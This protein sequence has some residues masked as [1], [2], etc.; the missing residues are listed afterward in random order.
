MSTRTSTHPAGRRVAGRVVEQVVDRTREPLARALDHDGLQL[1]LE[2][3]ARRVAPRPRDGLGD[4]IVEAH[5]LALA[6]RLVAARELDQVGDEH[7]EL[8]RL[9]LDVLQQPRALVGRQRL[10]LGQHLDVRAQ[11]GDRRAQ[12]VRGVGDELALGGDRAL[13]RVEHRVEVLG[14]LADL[15]VA[16]RPRSGGRGPRW[17]RCGAPPRS[18][19]RSARRRCARRDGRAG[20]R[21]RCR[22]RHT[23]S[24]IS[25]MRESTA[26]AGSSERPSCAAPSGMGVV[27]TRTCVPST[28]ASARKA[29]ATPAATS[30]TRSSTGSSSRSD[31]ATAYVFPL[32]SISWMYGVGPP[33]RAGQRAEARTTAATAGRRTATEVELVLERAVDLRTQLAADRDV[34]G[35]RDERHRRRHHDGD[36]DGHAAA[37]RQRAHQSLST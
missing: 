16:R 24:R 21:A 10:G 13:E 8:G 27:S 36:R 19:R 31:P 28:S 37:Q 35:E 4:E 7:A 14:Q 26:S 1:R 33:R 23:S 12:L 17:R 2:A 34:G 3:H 20:P 32:A 29:G 6:P 9:L 5:V 11:A 22:P 30:R 15:V 25:R 18:P